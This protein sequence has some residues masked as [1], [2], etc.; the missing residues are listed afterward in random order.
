MALPPTDEFYVNQAHKLC[1]VD[2]LALTHA[3]IFIY[4]SFLIYKI[5]HSLTDPSVN[6]F[7]F[8]TLH[9]Y[10]IVK[11]I[12][13]VC[14]RTVVMC[15]CV[16]QN[17]HINHMCQTRKTHNKNKAHMCDCCRRCRRRRSC[18]GYFYPYN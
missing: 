2:L 1:Y 5:K 15:L 7:W 14:Y 6:S 16:A 3:R 12:A 13:S 9:I 10:F 17:M 18:K 4:Y 11:Y 8:R